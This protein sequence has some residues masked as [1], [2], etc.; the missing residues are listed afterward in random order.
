MRRVINPLHYKFHFEKINSLLNIL[1]VNLC[2][3]EEWEILKSYFCLR[4]YKHKKIIRHC[5]VCMFFFCD[6]A[7]CVVISANQFSKSADFLNI[8]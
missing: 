1:S 5:D 6:C 8:R 7:A 2:V 4:L 3:C